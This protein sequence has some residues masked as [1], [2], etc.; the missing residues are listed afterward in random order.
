MPDPNYNSELVARFINR[1]ML[2]GKKSLAE[3]ILYKAFRI[4]EEKTK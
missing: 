1:I 2:K 4:I 3:Y